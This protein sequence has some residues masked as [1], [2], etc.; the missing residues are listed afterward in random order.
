MTPAE[1][2]RGCDLDDIATNSEY[3]EYREENFRK[4]DENYRLF[5]WARLLEAI[6]WLQH[7]GIIHNDLFTRNIMLNPAPVLDD[8]K[9]VDDRT[10]ATASQRPRVVIIDFGN[11][12]FV[13]D[14]LLVPRGLPQ[15]P[16]LKWWH[17]MSNHI[18]GGWVSQW[19]ELDLPARRRWLLREFGGENAGRYEKCEG[20]CD[21]DTI[22]AED[23]EYVEIRKS[24]W[25]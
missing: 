15:N 2:I 10:T 17:S 18:V 23:V 8:N 7:I 24:C 16:M 25:K 19:W 11:A 1:H 22:T 20:L 12:K 9:N 6:T 21:P 4:L 13:E 3:G 5:V 14:T